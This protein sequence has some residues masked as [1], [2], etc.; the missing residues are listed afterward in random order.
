LTTPAI[1]AEESEL[2]DVPPT[3]AVILNED[4]PPRGKQARESPPAYAP[5]A[6]C[7]GL[8]LVG[9]TDTDEEVALDP[10]QRCYLVLWQ[11]RAPQPALRASGAYPI[12]RCA[13]GVGLRARR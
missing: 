11:N 3:S 9:K 13:A 2:L 10:S 5:C 8:V 4:A 6:R 7:G 1:D 12:H